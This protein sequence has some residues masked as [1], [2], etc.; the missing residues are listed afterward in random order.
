MSYTEDIL[1]TLPDRAGYGRSS[2]IYTPV[3]IAKDMVN[4]LPDQVWN[5]NTTF[6][7]ICCKSGVFLHEIYLKLM[8]T[9]SLIQEFPDKAARRNH[10]LKNQLYGISPDQMCQLMS[11]RTVY[12]TIGCESNIISF[13][14]NYLRVMQNTDK[15]FLYNR[16]K[17]EFN[18][19]NFDVVIGNPPYN[20]GMDLD[21]VDLGYKVQNKYVCMITPAKWQTA[22]AN[23]RVSSKSI[24]YGQFRKLYVPHMSYVCFYPACKDVFDILQV[25]GITWYLLDKD[26]HEQCIVE[27]KCRYTKEFNSCEKRSIKNR[28]SLFNIGNEIVKYLGN[29]NIFT[30]PYQPQYKHFQVWTNTQV[31]GGGLS[32]QIA[33]RKTLFVGES[34]IEEDIGVYIEHSVASTCQFSS[35]NKSECESFISWLNTRFTR[36]FV[37]INISKLGPMLDDNCFR[38][39]PAPPSGK[40]D[41]IYTDEELY[42]AFNLPQKYIDVIEA[43]VKERK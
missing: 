29:Y 2:Q 40:F 39:V 38:F 23:Q 21:F 15:R 22:E 18:K 30:F 6:L 33:A 9:E 24:N 25:D 19:M 4:I 14:D 32:T 11:T 36:F 26:N 41:H 3:P 5:K 37:A 8:E 1:K 27:N 20:K 12:G 35:D 7:D 28:E 43:V 13:G 34:Y 42:K 16:L 31:P 10:I 17:E